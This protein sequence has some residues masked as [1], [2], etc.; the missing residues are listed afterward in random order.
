MLGSVTFN[1]N[2][3]NTPLQGQSP[4]IIN[5]SLSYS[6]AKNL[7]LSILYNRVGPRLKYRAVEG[8]ALNIY[9][10]S[11]DLIDFQ[12]TQKIFKGKVELKFAVVDLLAQPYR[13][14]YKFD[15]QP[16][17]NYFDSSKDKYINSQKFGT[18]VNVGVKV[19]L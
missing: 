3:V 2:Q 17:N 5:S 11:R 14:F 8:G 18:G 13:W 16:S 1:G 19:N 12:F 7:S 15:A 6:T 10:M 9:E 4:Y